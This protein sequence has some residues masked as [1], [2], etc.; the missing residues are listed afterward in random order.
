[1]KKVK[2]S[3]K[4]GL[5]E[6]YSD[7]SEKLKTAEEKM[8]TW[9]DEFSIDSAQDDMERRLKYLT[10][11]KFKVDDVRDEIMSALSRADSLLKK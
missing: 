4:A 2:S 11:E 5:T 3:A 7:V 6:A 9:M 1:M 10:G 8:N